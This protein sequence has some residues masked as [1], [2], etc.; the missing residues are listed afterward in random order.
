M[1]VPSPR[2]STVTAAPVTPVSGIVDLTDGRGY[3]RTAGYRRSATDLPLSAGEVRAYGLRKGDQIEGVLAVSA[4]GNGNANGS[5]SGKG[6]NSGGG[7]A[8]VTAVNGLRWTPPRVATSTTSP[9][10]TPTSGF[11]SKTDPSP[12]ARI[13][14][15]VAPIGKGSAASSSPRPRQARRRC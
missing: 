14:D 12:A 7:L 15:L 8:D 1:K 9:R 10:S 3:L 5:G 6:K 4:N 11:A 13:I 2:G